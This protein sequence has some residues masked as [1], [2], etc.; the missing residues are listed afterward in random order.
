MYILSFICF[1]VVAVGVDAVCSSLFLFYF[2]FFAFVSIIPI[3]CS[4]IRIL[5]FGCLFPCVVFL[6]SVCV[7]VYVCMSVCYVAVAA[8]CLL[9]FMLFA[10][11]FVCLFL[12]CFF[13][14]VCVCVC[15]CLFCF[16]FLLFLGGGLHCAACGLLVP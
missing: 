9:L 6:F 12:F 14:C 1:F 10:L 15:V 16:S 13:V 8:V 7:C 11:S 5:L 3:N 2:S 4:H